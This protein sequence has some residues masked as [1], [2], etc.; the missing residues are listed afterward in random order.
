MLYFCDLPKGTK[1]FVSSL[2]SD[3]VMSRSLKKK[4]KKGK[5][6]GNRVINA[7]Y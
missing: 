1:S 5:Q 3:R 7:F 6:T 2:R 4:K